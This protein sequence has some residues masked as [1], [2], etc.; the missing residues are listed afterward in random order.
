MI[1]EDS[2]E[3]L[4]R[5]ILSRRRV[6]LLAFKITVH[7]SLAALI[8]LITDDFSSRPSGSISVQLSFFRLAAY[9]TISQLLPV[10]CHCHCHRTTPT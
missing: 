1:L 2:F 7:F 10:H 8:F 4:L 6:L 3:Q 5:V 9:S